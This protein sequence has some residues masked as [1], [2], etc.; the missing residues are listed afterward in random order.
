MPHRQG[1][2]NKV[3]WEDLPPVITGDG[4]F[5]LPGMRGWLHPNQKTKANPRVV[6]P[7]VFGR[8]SFTGKDDCGGELRWKLNYGL[9][10]LRRC[11]KHMERCSGSP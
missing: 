2:V 3:D 1:H 11:N 9:P 5:G 4:G 6:T 8:R 7:L 10:R